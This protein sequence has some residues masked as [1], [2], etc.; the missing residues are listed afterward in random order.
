MLFKEQLQQVRV[1]GKLKKPKHLTA[2]PGSM[3]KLPA[4]VAYSISCAKSA[5][6]LLRYNHLQTKEWHS[7]RMSNA[8]CYPA[9][10]SL[11]LTKSAAT[12]KLA[13]ELKQ[14][15]TTVW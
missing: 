7:K 2:F 3:D 5:A 9:T 10:R 12:F 15:L 11:T 8:P 6:Q 4:V 13:T 14:P 1:T